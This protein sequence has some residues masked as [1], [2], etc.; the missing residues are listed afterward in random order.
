MPCACQ[1]LR[2]TTKKGGEIRPFK[3]TAEHTPILCTLSDV[4]GENGMDA[5]GRP[6][7]HCMCHGNEGGCNDFGGTG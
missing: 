4:P 3:C 6:V 7:L 2:K 1:L 5:L